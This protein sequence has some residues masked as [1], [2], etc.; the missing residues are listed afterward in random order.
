[1]SERGITNP[2]KGPA[3]DCRSIL[4]GL[5]HCEAAV[6]RLQTRDKRIFNTMPVANW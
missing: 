4:N 2:P 6:L 5:A 3:T 1:M